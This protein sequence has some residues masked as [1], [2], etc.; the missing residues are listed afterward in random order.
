MQGT[1]EVDSLVIV[2]G[3]VDCN[4]RVPSARLEC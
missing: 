1:A 4:I 2:I 3:H